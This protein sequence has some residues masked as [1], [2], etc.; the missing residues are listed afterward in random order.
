MHL[1]FPDDRRLV[2]RNRIPAAARRARPAAFEVNLTKRSSPQPQPSRDG[3]GYFK[4]VTEELLLFTG[5]FTAE[6]RD[7]F[8]ASR[9]RKRTPAYNK[10]DRL[11]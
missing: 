1:V 2:A 7:I 5:V 11:V 9:P 3:V 10:L 6:W 4:R 8:Y